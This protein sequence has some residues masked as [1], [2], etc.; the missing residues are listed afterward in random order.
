MY[1]FLRKLETSLDLILFFPLTFRSKLSLSSGKICLRAQYKQFIFCTKHFFVNF[2][3]QLG[4]VKS[5][6]QTLQVA[7]A[8]DR[9]NCEQM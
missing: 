2:F 9:E 6:I 8:R 4:S 7:Q 3:L 1:V 5:K